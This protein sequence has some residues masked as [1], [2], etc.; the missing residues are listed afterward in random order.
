VPVGQV[1]RS[2]SRRPP[3]QSG[4]LPRSPTC[5]MV[6]ELINNNP[7][8]RFDNHW[9][10]RRILRHHAVAFAMEVLE[11]QGRADPLMDFSRE[12]SHWVGRKFTGHLVIA[13][14]AASTLSRNQPPGPVR[15]QVAHA[16]LLLQVSRKESFM[17]P[18]DLDFLS[19]SSGT[20]GSSQ[21][22]SS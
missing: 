8:S 3:D 6:R 5:D 2:R 7:E 10:E 11:Y 19:S 4:S 13:R 21:R 12:F 15:S 9:I 14:C 18:I 16:Q 17:A 1:N 20:C 22:H